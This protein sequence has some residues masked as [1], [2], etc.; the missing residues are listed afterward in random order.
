MILRRFPWAV[1]DRERDASFRAFLEAESEN[2]FEAHKSR[3]RRSNPDTQKGAKKNGKR[4]GT[5]DATLA[6]NEHLTVPSANGYA[7]GVYPPARIL[8]TCST[9]CNPSVQITRARSRLPR[10]CP[11]TLNPFLA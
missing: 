7:G 5:A 9:L 11:T 8:F 10:F 2:P 1:P 3:S 4:L 6:S